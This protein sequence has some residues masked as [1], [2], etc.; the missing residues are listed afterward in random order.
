MRKTIFVVI[1]LI[2]LSFILSIYFYSHISEQMATHWNSQG[3]VNG[4]MS[5]LYGLFLIPLI[6]TGIAVM[7]LIIPKID[8]LKE[9]IGK[10]SNYYD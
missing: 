7:F 10:F 5:K 4:Y 2:F 6:I 1:G 9:N 3:E 8:P